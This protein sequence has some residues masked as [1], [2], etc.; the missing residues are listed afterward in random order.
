V[1]DDIS[2][3]FV[4][5]EN[6]EDRVTPTVLVREGEMDGKPDINIELDIQFDNGSAQN[7]RIAGGILGLEANKIEPACGSSTCAGSVGELQPVSPSS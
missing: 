3:C 5:D 6:H 2:L 4:H 7:D 1:N